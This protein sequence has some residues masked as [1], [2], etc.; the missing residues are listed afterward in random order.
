MLTIGLHGVPDSD[1]RGVS[2]D[3]GVAV[4]EGGR[5]VYCQELERHTG[6]KHD[7][8]MADHFEDLAAAILRSGHPVQ[9]VLANTFLG[10]GFASGRGML[11]VVGEKGLAVPEILA[12]CRGRLVVDGASVPAQFLTICHEM[13]HLGT[14][15]PFFGPFLPNSLLI[16]IDG[17]AYRSC[18]SAWHFDGQELTCLDHGWHAGIKGA[19]NNFNDSQLSRWILGLGPAEHLSMPGKLMGLASFGTPDRNAM[20]WM[21]R[22]GWLRSEPGSRDEVREQLRRELPELGIEEFSS[23]DPGSQTLAACMQAHLEDQVLAYIREFRERTGSAHLYYSGGAAL[24]I[25]ANTRIERELG[26]STVSIPPAPSDAGL[27]LGAAAF[28]SWRLGQTIRKHSPFLNAAEPVQPADPD[29]RSVPI[30]RSAEEAAEAVASGRIVGVCTG[31]GE[32]GPRALGCRSLLARPDSVALR[33]RLS[34][35]VKGREWYRPVAPMLLSEVAEQALKEY[36]RGSALAR[37]M[38][39][40]WRIVPEWS[41]AF[42]G[43]VHA[44]GTVRAQVIDGDEPELAHI[45]RLLDCLRRRH[46]IHGVINTSFNARGQPMVRGE[47]DALRVA[48]ELGL[49]SLWLPARASGDESAGSHL[50]GLAPAMRDSAQEG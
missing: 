50:C 18:A 28:V 40:A 4:M 32:V 39:G 7:G 16:H 30:L 27:A 21:D 29:C 25:H 48:S 36:R 6:R 37:F 2:H 43:C 26:F 31:D 38:L 8:S 12:E 1:A 47:S 42:A 10:C 15:L 19:V 22:H 13:A 45:R 14:C 9:V 3:H 33:R 17:G 20:A 35:E 34:E 46:G 41:D 5:V 23:R 11:E 24:N 44:D 49:D